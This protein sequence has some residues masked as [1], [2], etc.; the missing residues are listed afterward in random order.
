MLMSHA[1]SY[2]KF[3]GKEE[4]DG[5]MEEL[6]MSF[7]GL[8]DKVIAQYTVAKVCERV[9]HLCLVDLDD[10]FIEIA[11]FVVFPSSYL[12]YSGSFFPCNFCLLWF[13]SH[14]C[15]FNFWIFFIFILL[16]SFKNK[17]LITAFE[18]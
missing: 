5:D 3:R 15:G 10:P 8:E 2:L 7:S 9:V 1:V 18:M 6:I 4:E 16:S 12:F 17:L 14:L 13:P 11:H